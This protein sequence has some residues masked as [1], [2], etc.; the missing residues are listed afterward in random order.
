MKNKSLERFNKK[1][2]MKKKQQAANRRKLIESLKPEVREFAAR[3][4][5]KLGLYQ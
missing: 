2:R 3:E 5:A 4:F 1:Q